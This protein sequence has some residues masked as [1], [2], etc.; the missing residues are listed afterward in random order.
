MERLLAL[1]DS[2]EA[3]I[4]TVEGGAVFELPMKSNRV[5]QLRD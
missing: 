3:I 1:W 4:S 2:M 5:R